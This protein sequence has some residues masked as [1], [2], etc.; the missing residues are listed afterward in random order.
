MIYLSNFQCI[1]SQIISD[2]FQVKISPTTLNQALFTQ[3]SHHNMDDM[4]SKHDNMY[5]PTRESS[6]G[7]NNVLDSWIAISL[8]HMEFKGS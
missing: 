3:W 4:M 6:N 7:G 1:P 8:G 2:A 5:S